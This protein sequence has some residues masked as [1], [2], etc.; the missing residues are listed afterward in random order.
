[1]RATASLDRLSRFAAVEESCTARAGVARLIRAHLEWVVNSGAGICRSH[2]ESQ[3][4][5]EG[6]RA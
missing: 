6:G 4:R 3:T 1:L 2:P 5:P